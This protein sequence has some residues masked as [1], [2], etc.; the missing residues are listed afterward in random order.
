MM[1]GHSASASVSAGSTMKRRFAAGSSRERHISGRR[2]P[3]QLDREQIDQQDRRQEG[4]HR[5]HAESGAGHEAVERTAAAR[6]ADDRQGNADRQRDR[7]GPAASVRAIPAA[8]RSPPAARSGRCG[9]S[10]RNRPAAHCR[11]SPDSATRSAGRAPCRG[12][13]PRRSPASPGH[14]GWCRRDRPAA[15]TRSENVSSE[16][17]ISTGTRY[18]SLR[19]TKNTMGG[20]SFQAR[21]TSIIPL[22]I[23][24][25][26]LTF[27]LEIA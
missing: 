23:F 13:A 2:Q 22:Y 14:R 12:A 7:A 21:D 10:G 4:R 6:R 20:Y 25:R 8:A 1:P 17:A 5:Q 9:T 24:G 15:A 3:A 26:P 27:A 19:A 18:R 16:T 11:A